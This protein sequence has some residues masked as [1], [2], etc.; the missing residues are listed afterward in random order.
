MNWSRNSPDGRRPVGGARTLGARSLGAPATETLSR[1]FE[2]P[3][4]QQPAAENWV[5]HGERTPRAARRASSVVLL[6]DGTHGVETYLG[7]RRGNSPLGAIAFPGGSEE[8][9]D[10]AAVAWFGPTPGQWAQKLGILDHR[11]A[12]AR[13]VCAARELFEETGVLLAGA[14]ELSV[15]ENCSS[16]EWMEL[17]QA[18]AEQDL[19]FGELLNGR[20]LGLRTDLLRPLARWFSPDFA[21][22]R[23]DTWYFAAAMPVRQQASL[24]DGKGTWAAWKSAAALL[25]ERSTTVLGDEVAHRDTVGK[26]LSQTTVP[27]VEVILEKIATTRGTIAY[28]A[29]R[30]ELRT[31]HPQ[32]VDAGGEF[33]LEVSVSTASEGGICWRSR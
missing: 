14:D 17:R 16:R 6:R 5:N 13:I 26:T 1:H 22:R 3:L 23:F 31:F 2:L 32:L 18:V 33:V 15:L 25:E 8:H 4:D 19:S 9:D 27:A 12:R 30:R 11:E 10:D 7:Y 20:G 29:H 21:H 24:L 28:L